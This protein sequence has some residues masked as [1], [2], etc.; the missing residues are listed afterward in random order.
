MFTGCL[1]SIFLSRCVFLQQAGSIFFRGASAL[2]AAKKHKYGIIF[3]FYTEEFFTDKY[4]GNFANN[5][6]NDLSDRFISK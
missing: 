3:Y 4:I 6:C 5:I 1:C 2:E